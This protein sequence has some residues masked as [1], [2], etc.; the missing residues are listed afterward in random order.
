MKLPLV[1]YKAQTANLSHPYL[2][3]S[4]QRKIS[5]G[6]HLLMENAIRKYS[7]PFVRFMTSVRLG[8]MNEAAGAGDASA[9]PPFKTS[10]EA[11]A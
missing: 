5:A 1:Y 11:E 2:A 6:I 8:D 7:L 3:G 10:A 9:C 4:H